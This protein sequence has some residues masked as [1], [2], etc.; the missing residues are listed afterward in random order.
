MTYWSPS[1]TPART[2]LFAQSHIL[3]TLKV[4]QSPPNL[5]KTLISFYQEEQYWVHRT[6]STLKT[7]VTSSIDTHDL[8]LASP[9][10][11]TSPDISHPATPMS[12]PSRPPTSLS[13][14]FRHDSVGPGDGTTT[15]LPLDVGITMDGD[16]SAQASSWV[17]RQNRMRLKLD[18]GPKQKRRRIS[19]ATAQPSAHILEMFSDLM[20]ARME[21]CQRVARMVDMREYYYY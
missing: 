3:R 21:S 8:F 20:D 12:V 4:P 7:S 10:S 15:P 17:R 11:D 18:G 16:N 9:A 1:P 14:S 6:R 13:S 5:L 19:H 2:A